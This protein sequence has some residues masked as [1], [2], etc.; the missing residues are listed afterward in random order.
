MTPDAEPLKAMNAMY[1]SLM[2]DLVGISAPPDQGAAIAATH[3][4]VGMDLRLTHYLGWLENYGPERYAEVL[5]QHG[6]RP[7]YGSMLTRTLSA[8]KAEWDHMFEQLP[9]IARLA[10]TIG[11]TRAGVVVLPFD[12]RLDFPANRKQHLTRLA[13]VAPILADHGV[14]VGLE[15]VSPKTR[16]ADATFQFIH[17]LQAMRELIADAGQHNVGLMLDCFHWHCAG[18]TTA[19]L[20][21]LAAD[22]VVVVHINDAPRDAPTDQLDIRNRSLPAETGVIDIAGFL[23]ALKRIGYTGPVTAEPT[24]PR[25]PGTDA[26]KAA[27]LT[28]RAVRDAMR[29]AGCGCDEGQPT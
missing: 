16:R 13:Q 17:N 15:Y 9:R 21:Q 10:Q 20:E 19:D 26:D 5:A 28:G 1:P 2:A 12:D 6:L 8:S 11:F 3:G 27:A 23:G 18:E 25:W 22:D 29:A 4:F 24:N 14:R 7:G